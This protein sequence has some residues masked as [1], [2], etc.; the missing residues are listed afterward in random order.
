VTPTRATLPLSGLAVPALSRQ[1]VATMQQRLA[2]I[3]SAR[4][5]VWESKAVYVPGKVRLGRRAGRAAGEARG[6]AAVG[7]GCLRRRCAGSAWKP[8]GRGR[9]A[10]QV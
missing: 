3:T 2:K 7:G 6:R 4:L 9:L 10:L 1:V 8:A 5:T